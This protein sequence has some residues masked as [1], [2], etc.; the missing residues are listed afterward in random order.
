MLQNFKM[1]TKNWK[2]NRKIYKLVEVPFLGQTQPYRP[3][4][5][6]IFGA[7]VPLKVNQVKKL[8]LKNLTTLSVKWETV[9]WRCSLFDRIAHERIFE[10]IIN[11][12]ENGL[13]NF[14]SFFDQLCGWYIIHRTNHMV[15]KDRMSCLIMVLAAGVRPSFR[16]SLRTKLELE[17]RLFKTNMAVPS[18]FFL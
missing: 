7:T 2:I 12:F 5:P 17:I 13:F 8:D 16:P 9:S 4:R 1:A 15:S 18:L 11:I 10:Q 6:Q 14:H 3:K